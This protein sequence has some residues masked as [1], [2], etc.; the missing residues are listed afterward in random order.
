MGNFQP[1]G[2]LEQGILNSTSIPVDLGV[3]S[4]PD[5]FYLQVAVI[6][7]DYTYRVSETDKI[8]RV[9]ASCDS[10][11]NMMANAYCSASA[12]GY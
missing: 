6:S 3:L 11:G 9:T 10:Y 2:A 7:K 5:A 8:Q 12:S 4:N 1:S